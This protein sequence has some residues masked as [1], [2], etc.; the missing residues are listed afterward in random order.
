M[1]Y[2]QEYYRL[3]ALIISFVLFVL[4]GGVI[5]RRRGIMSLFGLVLS[6]V[7]IAFVMFPLMVSGWNAFSV[8]VIGSFLIAGS[9]ILIA[10]GYCRRTLLALLATCITLVCAIVMAVVAV[11]LTRLFGLGSEESVFLQLDPT[12]HVDPRGLLLAGIIIGA[13][14]V[15]DDVTTTQ[16][17]A[18]EEVRK[19]NPSS[20]FRQLYSAGV[21][22]GREHVASMI[23]TLVLAYVGASLPLLLLFSLG[24]DVPAWVT[25][26]S[27]FFAEEIVRTL[28][29]SAALLLAV[30]IATF[31]AA[32][33]FSKRSFVA[34]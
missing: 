4:L 26:N 33:G 3:P 28:V 30:P 32:Y 34:A 8:S 29:G 14:G 9:T 22:V 24:G 5:G 10:H 11:T 7:I 27:A 31:L 20:T 2:F 23:N 25:L 15:L 13:L 17:A 16:V 18:V 6:I 19:A 21:S 1:Y 12:I